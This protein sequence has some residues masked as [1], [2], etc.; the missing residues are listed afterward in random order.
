MAYIGP[1]Q[2]AEEAVARVTQNLPGTDMG[3]A[4]RDLVKSM[5][6]MLATCDGTP[7]GEAIP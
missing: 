4:A 1:S 6:Q 5:S 7:P 2:S 3:E